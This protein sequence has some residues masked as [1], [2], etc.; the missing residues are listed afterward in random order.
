MVSLGGRIEKYTECRKWP[1]NLL[2][3]NTD[4]LIGGL[5]VV[6]QSKGP[7]DQGSTQPDGVA[8]VTD[9]DVGKSVRQRQTKKAI[10]IRLDVDVI[11]GFKAGGPGWQARMNKALRQ[12]LADQQNK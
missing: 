1:A 8:I 3:Q 2:G 12:H 7:I 10:S 5:Y 9:L 6:Y 4:D 11:E